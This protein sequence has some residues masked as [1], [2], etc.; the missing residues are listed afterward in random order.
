M[1]ISAKDTSPSSKD[2]TTRSL[3][4][5]TLVLLAVAALGFAI[6]E[7]PIARE[8]L[9]F[10][11]WLV[12]LGGWGPVIFI[13][14]YAAGTVLLVPGSALAL[15]AGPIFGLVLGTVVIE[16]GSTLGAALPFLIA[17]YAARER[18]AAYLAR[19]PK[20]GAIDH[21][22]AIGGWKIV[23]LLRM[24]PLVPYSISNYLY[25]L[26]SIRFWPYV[27]VSAVA[28]LPGN[29]A[30][31]YFGSVAA[32][33]LSSASGA[34]A[35]EAGAHE[36]L[37]WA[38]RIIGVVATLLALRLITRLARQALDQPAI[39]VSEDRRTPPTK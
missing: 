2:R 23:G 34:S 22:V 14:V 29:L 13:L 24:T 21:Q 36:A 26:T 30:F 39:P 18:V 1:N 10:K 27:I 12:G 33:G 20:L 28:M 32:E 9:V 7:W 16:V 6:H 25:G 31:V 37:V 5:Y 35:Q 8:V 19:Y 3:W 38:L 17:R 11:E 15:L 4:K